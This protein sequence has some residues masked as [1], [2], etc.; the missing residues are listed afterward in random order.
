MNAPGAKKI[1]T[2]ADYVRRAD[3]AGPSGGVIPAS[4][5]RTETNLT[6]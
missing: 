5:M 4:Q 2:I 6:Q 3:A 1:L